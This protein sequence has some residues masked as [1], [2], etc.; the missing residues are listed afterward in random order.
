[1]LA[2]ALETHRM[3]GLAH[4]VSPNDDSQV[5]EIGGLGLVRACV[6]NP[7]GTSNLILQGVGRIRFTEWLDGAAHRRA[8]VK[9]LE[10]FCD[11]DDRSRDLRLHIWE[12]CQKLDQ[13]DEKLP[14]HFRECLE[15]RQSPGAFADLVS[16]TLVQDPL[17]RQ[18]L[19]EELDVNR[20]LEI[21][22]AYLERC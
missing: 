11:S 14:N 12:F 9:L 1:M 18:R 17:V 3:F 19:L 4:L 22:A 20:R 10:S 8:K 7:D 16:A 5:F 15:T 13:G 21:L 6:A 2:E